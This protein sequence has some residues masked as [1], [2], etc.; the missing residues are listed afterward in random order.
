[1][2]STIGAEAHVLFI[3]TPNSVC[4]KLFQQFRFSVC[5]RWKLVRCTGKLVMIELEE[6]WEGSVD[7]LNRHTWGFSL[8]LLWWIGWNQTANNS[9][10]L[11]GL[12]GALSIST[13][14]RNTSSSGKFRF[15]SN[16]IQGTAVRFPRL[17]Q[18]CNL[19]PSIAALSSSTSF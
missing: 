5:Q 4:V 1:M 8:H 10:K 17:N 6:N 11:Y 13:K 9:A 14:P 2:N 19:L 12:D 16:L 3:W 15:T 7:T 18:F